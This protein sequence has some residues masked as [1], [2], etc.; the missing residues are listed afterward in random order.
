VLTQEQ[1]AH[2]LFPLG[3]TPKPEIRAE[4]ARA[5]CS[6]PTSRTPTTSASSATATPGLA[7]EK[8]GAAAPA[9]GDI[10][11]VDGEVLGQHEGT[12]HFTIGQRKGLRLG[13]PAPDGKPR[14]VLDISPVDGTVTVGS[15]AELRVDGLTAIRPRWC[16]TPPAVLD[17]EDVTVQL[18]AHGDEHR[19]RVTVRSSGPESAI[20]PPQPDD[21]VEVELLDP[22]SGIAAGQAVVIYAGTR[23]VGSATIATTRRTEVDA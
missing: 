18:R 19:A 20:A 23:V 11:T 2:S 3:D 10:V 21:L 8:L 15:R 4:A 16:G 14:F 1:L 7:D 22:A 13:H 5:G 17:G 12:Y 6:S 9:P